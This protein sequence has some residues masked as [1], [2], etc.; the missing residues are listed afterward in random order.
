MTPPDVDLESL[1]FTSK[2]STLE[3]SKLAVFNIVSHMTELLVVF[4][5]V[6]VTGIRANLLSQASVHFGTDIAKSCTDQGKSDLPILAKYEHLNT[7][8]AHTSESFP[9]D[10]KSSRGNKLAVSINT[11][12]FMTLHIEA[13]R[14]DFRF[15]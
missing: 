12:C 5:W 14:S 4:L 3:Q 11:L 13:P 8:W 1:S 10:S 2:C 9:F 15:L 7:I 6:D